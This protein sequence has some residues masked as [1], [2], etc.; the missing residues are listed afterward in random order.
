MSAIEDAN[1][2]SATEDD[3]IQLE[4]LLNG[5]CGLRK[6]DFELLFSVNTATAKQIHLDVVLQLRMSDAGEC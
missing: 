5:Y 6:T 2:Q 1:A 4:Y 3:T